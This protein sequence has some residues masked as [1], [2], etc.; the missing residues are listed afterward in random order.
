M[1]NNQQYDKNE[2]ILMRLIRAQNE[3]DVS[4]ILQDPFFSTNNVKWEAIGND[5]GNCRI[6]Q[7]QMSKSVD[8]LCEKPINSF[9]AILIKECRK[10]GIEPNDQI[11][12]P[13]SMKEAAEKFLQVPDGD[14]LKLSNE[15]RREIASLISIIAEGGDIPNIIIADRGEGQRPEE[16]KNTLLSIDKNN[17][18]QIK[19]VQGKFNMGGTG[20]LDFCGEKKYQLILSRRSLELDKNSD[21][22]FTLVRLKPDVPESYK[23]PWFEYFTDVNEDIFRIPGK[24]LPILP[25]NEEL[26]DGCYIKLFSYELPSRT[27]ITQRGLWGP[28]SRK[29]YSPILPFYI[30]E[31]RKKYDKTQGKND[32]RLLSGIKYRSEVN[33]DD[34]YKTIPIKCSIEEFG[35]IKVEVT[36]F[37]HSSQQKK[38]INVTS[39]YV[40]NDPLLLTINGQTHYEL[41]KQKLRINAKVPSLAD[42]MMVHVDLTKHDKIFH[43]IFMGSR[44]RVRTDSPVYK[45]LITRIFDDLRIHPEIIDLEDDYKRFNNES[46][47]KDSTI[48]GLIKHAIHDTPSLWKLFAAG[49]AI[50]EFNSPKVLEEPLPFQGKSIPTRLT[51]KSNKI[52]VGDYEKKVPVD[53]SPTF[54]YFITDAEN[55]YDI[56][57]DGTERLHVKVPI[58]MHYTNFGLKNG[59][60]SLKLLASKDAIEGDIPNEKLIVTLDRPNDKPLECKVV[61]QYYKPKSGKKG[62][63]RGSRKFPGINPPQLLKVYRKDWK[64]E[65]D[66]EMV[67]KVNLPDSVTIN[68]DCKYLQDFISIK[69][70]SEH[71][72]ILQRYLLAIYFMAIYHYRQWE[73]MD[74]FEEG[75]NRSLRATA[76]GILPTISLMTDKDILKSIAVDAIKAVER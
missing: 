5:K 65:W 32:K 31:M 55:G 37:Q 57:E 35:E 27:D 43:K 14:I 70:S 11:K 73:T 50:N 39:E 58:G 8:A 15:K 48:M 69:T 23:L 4:E 10:R 47:T 21:W 52:V 74:N 61:L 29:L 20:V 12:A 13:K 45:S 56:A 36:V 54:I 9:D 34:I 75:Y 53:G 22:G 76:E 42:Y 19:F 16:F 3:E 25:W 38:R 18:T 6:I 72:K 33:K 62:I 7:N 41:D 68:V 49:D 1:S 46:L 63:E 64:N 66:E 59:Q 44:D 30:Y 26:L 67:A 24:P 51:V 60:I 71:K 2:S 28:L 40:G 17:K